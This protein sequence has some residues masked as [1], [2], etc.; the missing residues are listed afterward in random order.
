[1]SA[2]PIN[3]VP[4]IDDEQLIIDS[5]IKTCVQFRNEHGGSCNEE[6]QL[7]KQ[8]LEMICIGAFIQSANER[9]EI[10]SVDQKLKIKPKTMTSN[11]GMITETTLNSNDPE[12]KIKTPVYRPDLILRDIE[13]DVI[14]H[15]EI[16]ENNHRHY[17]KTAEEKRR[18]YIMKCFEGHKYKLLRFDTTMFKSKLEMANAFVQLCNNIRGIGGAM[19]NY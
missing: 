17:D 12:V 4:K 1:M 15:I 16:D 10:M 5:Y 2:K 11:D 7:K 8:R 18:E 9:F 6:T 14:Y 19:T 13:Y 3:P